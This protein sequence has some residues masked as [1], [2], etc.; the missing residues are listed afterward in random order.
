MLSVI[1]S[2]KKSAIDFCISVSSLSFNCILEVIVGVGLKRW[3][4]LRLQ[5]RVWTISSCHP[6][7]PEFFPCSF[8]VLDFVLFLG[9]LTAL[10]MYPSFH[11]G[12]FY[13]FEMALQVLLGGVHSGCIECPFSYCW[14]KE[15]MDSVV[16]GW[17]RPGYDMYLISL[18][19]SFVDCP[20][21]SNQCSPGYTD[22]PYYRL[23]GIFRCMLVHHY[24]S[25]M[26]LDILNI[27]QA[28]WDNMLV[29]R[30]HYV[31]VSQ[32]VLPQPVQ[33]NLWWQKPP[34]PDKSLKSH[35][36]FN[37]HLPF[38]VPSRFKGPARSSILQSTYS[39]RISTIVW[40][41]YGKQGF[42]IPALAPWKMLFSMH[43]IS[44]HT[45]ARERN[46]PLPLNIMNFHQNKIYQVDYL[47]GDKGCRGYTAW[48]QTLEKE[49]KWVLQMDQEALQAHKVTWSWIHLHTT[50]KTYDPHIDLWCM[51]RTWNLL[52]M[53]YEFQMLWILL[54]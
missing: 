6:K 8:K 28:Q 15:I 24:S 53:A 26:D 44:H 54:P 1:L 43:Q 4:W 5:S 33:D 16:L 45:L 37:L 34:P 27:G 46:M 52:C 22:I 21:L 13:S 47:W 41:Q 42:H 2:T 32:H 12:F 39:N 10:T 35:L 50:Y 9:P 11:H 48:G 23:M 7:V 38:F 17:T 3:M 18:C 19:E 51:Q 49:M 31:N 29:A 25:G 14:P 20:S 40:Y 36:S 30:D